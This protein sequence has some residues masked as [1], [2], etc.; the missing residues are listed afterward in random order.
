MWFPPKWGGISQIAIRSLIGIKTQ[1]AELGVSLDRLLAPSP[2][3]GR[4]TFLVTLVITHIR[5]PQ[6]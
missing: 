5:G 6:S 3:W 1:G 4:S 2:V